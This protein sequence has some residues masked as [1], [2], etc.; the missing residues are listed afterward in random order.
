[1]SG[2]KGRIALT[3]CIPSSGL[4]CDGSTFG[5]LRFRFGALCFCAG[6]IVCLNIG[7]TIYQKLS[8][9]TDGCTFGSGSLSGASKCFGTLE[10]IDGSIVFLPACERSNGC[11][12][13]SSTFVDSA[14]SGGAFGG[15]AL[16]GSPL[17]GGALGGSALNG[18][19]FGGDA[20][21]NSRKQ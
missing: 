17:G 6:S 12:L 2:D 9:D 21:C 15:G 19:A 20:A 8:H 5:A 11:A 10:G 14:L 7:L 4:A 13:A 18:S 1:M 3:D 16:G